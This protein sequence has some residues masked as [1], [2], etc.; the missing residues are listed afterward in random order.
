MGPSSTLQLLNFWDFDLFEGFQIF[1]KLKRPKTFKM[2]F[3]HQLWLQRARFPSKNFQSRLADSKIR[4]N[5]EN[6]WKFR[7]LL[8][9]LRF[10]KFS[11]FAKIR[12]NSWKIENFQ[13]S[14]TLSNFWK[15][16]I[17]GRFSKSQRQ[18]TMIPILDILAKIGANTRQND[19]ILPIFDPFLPKFQNCRPIWKLPTVA[20]KTLFWPF[21]EPKWPLV[22]SDRP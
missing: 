13:N 2:I 19:L 9:V 7:K 22:Y 12:E 4:E 11:N 21:L 17:F 5:R 6:S 14:N 20:S 1:K 10:W 3:L 16:A 15:S 18:S 8:R